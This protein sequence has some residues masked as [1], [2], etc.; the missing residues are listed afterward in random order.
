MSEAVYKARITLDVMGVADSAEAF[1]R[2]L[3]N[4]GLEGILHDA[5]SEGLIR[6][7]HDV[8][9]VEHIHRGDVADELRRIGND[10]SFFEDQLE[11]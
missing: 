11:D 8:A 10:G 9:S 3:E 4:S 1:R 7:G 2:L 6:S 5:D